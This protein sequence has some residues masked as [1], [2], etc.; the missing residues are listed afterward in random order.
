MKARPNYMP[1]DQF[2]QVIEAIP[3]LMLRKYLV[4]DVQMFMK[5]SYWLALRF[6]ETLKL[7]TENFDFEINEAWLGKTKTEKGA[8]ANIPIQF[9]GE[10]MTYLEGKS[11]PLFEGWQYITVLKWIERLGKILDIPAWTTPQKETGEKTKTH[12]FRKS[13]GKDMLYG[14][15]GNRAPI[16]FISK[17]LRHGGK[18]PLGTTIKYL[19][20]GSE[21]VKDWWIEQQKDE[22]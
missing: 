9:R 14:E 5:I 22:I 8:T 13:I 17:T 2:D 15:Y 10:L 18:D 21:E 19:K 11:G 12:I 7:T 16:T 3:R 6:G 20:I 1:P 4:V